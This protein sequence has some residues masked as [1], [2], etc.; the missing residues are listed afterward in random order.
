MSRSKT[1]LKARYLK[2]RIRLFIRPV[3]LG[4]LGIISFSSFCIWGLAGSHQST[5]TKLAQVHD[6]EVSLTPR[7]HQSPLNLEPLAGKRA[8]LSDGFYQSVFQVNQFQPS[9]RKY[10]PLIS[11]NFQVNEIEPSRAQNLYAQETTPNPSG[12][13][14]GVTPRVYTTPQSA[15]EDPTNLNDNPGYGYQPSLSDPGYGYQPSFNNQ[16]SGQTPNSTT[17]SQPGFNNQDYRQT[18]NSNNYSQPGFN[19][20]NSGQTPNSAGYGYQQ[21][22]YNNPY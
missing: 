5:A 6:S 8:K 20:Q 21:P 15:P 2:A 13:T 9:R 17:Y 19:N 4:S 14:W 10:L 3:F 11:F 1:S 7:I 18:P 22:N 16:N 12:Y